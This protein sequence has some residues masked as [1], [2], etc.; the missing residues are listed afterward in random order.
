VVAAGLFAGSV[1]LVH[2][3]AFPQRAVTLVVPWP[4]G[5]ASDFVARVIAKGLSQRLQQPVIVEN[6]V[7]G[8]GTLGAARVLSAAPDGHTLLL[9]SPLDAILAPLV[10]PA[11]TYRPQDLRPIAILGH[12]DVMV[13]VR[14]DLGVNSLAE[15]AAALRAAG[16]RPLSLCSPGNG[17]L[18]HLVGVQL[19]ARAGA[20]VLHVPYTGFNQ[21]INDMSGGRVDMA[22]L[23]V[24]GP[25]PGFVDRGSIKALAVLGDAPNRRLPAVPPA[26]KT[27]GFEDV[28]VS[29][30][31]GVHARTG[32][33]DSIAE[34]LLREI[35]G[36][37]ADP[38]VRRQIEESGAT[39]A[40][41]QSLQAAGA[42]YAAEIAAYEGMARA[43]GVAAR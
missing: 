26:R 30:W 17:S 13:A 29:V 31:A 22:L 15:L 23:P 8:G 10:A 27:S 19:A 11:A 2:A 5:G 18:Y 34:T 32:V 20:Q 40:P 37:M 25:F 16:K 28:R 35:Q 33:P 4:A 43:I 42:A 3:Q 38:A 39:V 21:C 12:T 1:L 14:N 24:A 9:S 36:V 41:P 6:V 7:G